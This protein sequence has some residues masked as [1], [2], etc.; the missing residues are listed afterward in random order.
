M[1][2]SPA[3][4]TWSAVQIALY[5]AVGPGVHSLTEWAITVSEVAAFAFVGVSLIHRSRL[6]AYAWFER[7]LVLSIFF[8]QVFV[9]TEAQLAGVL[10]L[11]V[12]LVVW[13]FLRSAIRLEQARTL[14]VAETT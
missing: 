10:D 6:H 3:L 1:R 14:P 7:S 11:I 13:F 4:A 2:R 8:T 5:A 12:S 9:F